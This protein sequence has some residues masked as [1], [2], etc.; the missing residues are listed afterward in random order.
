MQTRRT[1]H[2]IRGLVIAGGV[3]A[4]ITLGLACLRYSFA[5]PLVRLSY[6]LPFLWRTT[7]D[8]HDIVLV[9]L[10]EYSAKQLN[11]PL[12]DVWNRALHVRLLDRLTQ[13]K[14]RLVFYDIVFDAPAPDP[15]ADAA[16]AES[17]HRHGKVILGAALDIV[18]RVGSVREERVSAP[19]KLLRKAAAGYGLVAFRPVDPD[20]G[21]REMYLRGTSLVPTATW[22]AAEAVRANVTH[23]PREKIGP[24]WLNYYGP[25]DSFSSV[26]IAQ[27]LAPDGIP[28]GYFKDRIV[29]V[30]PRSAVRYLGLG[31]DE[32]ATP[33]SRWSRQFS[34]GLE[35]HATILL[36]LLR[37][38]WLT[39]MPLN[40]ETA[41][42]IFLGFVAGSLGFFRPPLASVLAVIISM[43]IACG[44]S[45]LVW[46][47]RTWFAWLIPA[48]VQMPLGLAWAVGSQ[49]LFESRRRKALRTA[50]GF[51]LS[52]QMADKIANSDFNLRPGGEIVEATVLF[53]DLENFTTL[54]EHLDPSEVSAIL[55]AY[56]ER[57][58]RCILEKK[59]IIIKYI[60]DAVMAAWGAPVDE[61]E[62]AMR[63]AEAACDLRALTEIEVRGRKLRTRIGIN[64][65]KVLAGNLG[66]SF[67]FDYTMIGD[68]TN[69]A[70]R[71]ESL[72]KYLGTQV[73]I[74]QAVTE[75]LNHKFIT[76]RLGEFRVAGKTDSVTIYE[77]LG[78]G[79]ADSAQRA[80][81]DAFEAGLD[82]FRTGKFSDA[83]D[84]MNRTCQLRDGF[85]G[86]A[87]FYLRKIAILRGQDVKNW[88]GIIELSEK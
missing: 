18:E 41:V 22:V 71:L 46:Y 20:Y 84:S 60:G 1:K 55:I 21:V 16:F 77:L 23:E 13:E 33:Y 81:I 74:S 72:N 67:R 26:N 34:P 75:Q 15:A 76:R 40:W 86:P 80:W 19:T 61:P 42:I 9:Y 78:C 47:H 50:F 54:S 79:E 43:A 7:L 56:F 85:D 10:D 29:M 36:N 63:A 58:T 24:L 11:Q 38:E 53:T 52:P 59:G 48:A 57:T 3:L 66:S 32:F 44:A 31:K 88:D 28:P 25:R 68:T 4:T 51:Y 70:S 64:S 45:W 69:L 83:A 82:K 27:A 35:V 37:S 8:T 17:I 5:E 39:R 65:G 6:D 62:H 2:L 87:E 30:G 49:Y 12:D 73:L 14:A